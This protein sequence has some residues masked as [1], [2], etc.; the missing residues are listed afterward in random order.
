MAECKIFLT[1]PC[2][3]QP[4]ITRQLPRPSEEAL[5]EQEVELWV[6]QGSEPGPEAALHC[7]SF[8]RFIHMHVFYT[9]ACVGNAT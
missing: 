4:R 6:L 1:I 8:I 7:E 9:Y 5:P 2:C 3:L